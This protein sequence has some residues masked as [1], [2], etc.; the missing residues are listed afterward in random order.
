MNFVS[1]RVAVVF[2]VEVS[3]DVRGV[4]DGEV[5]PRQ[6]QSGDLEIFRFFTFYSF[7]ISI[8]SKNSPSSR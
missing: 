3:E 7:V 8:V 5:L 6:L 2:G 4:V 1:Y